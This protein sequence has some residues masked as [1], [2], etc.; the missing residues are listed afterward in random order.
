M[1]NGRIVPGTAALVLLL[2]APACR[3]SVSLGNGVQGDGVA[4][5]DT[6]EIPT[7]DSI[8][9]DGTVKLDFATGPLDRLSITGD[10]NLLPLVS[11]TVTGTKLVV[12]ETQAV[13]S[14]TPLVVSVHSPALTRIDAAG[15]SGVIATGLHGTSFTYTSSG[16]AN[17]ELTGQVDSLEIQ[18]GG[19]G[20]VHAAGLTAKQAHVAI[21][22]AGTVE[23]NA[24]DKLKAD[25]SGV[26]S[27][28]YR[29]SPSVEKN[30]SGMGTVGPL[31]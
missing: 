30:V 10:E 22:G 6:R 16:V 1:M 25:V 9:V 24:T 7:F 31:G 26:G 3:T 11:T 28:K 5:S 14:K 17:A 21:S 12:H 29:G 15:I 20:E 23:V 13:H 2:C 19:T 4:K 18:T 27:V 8:E